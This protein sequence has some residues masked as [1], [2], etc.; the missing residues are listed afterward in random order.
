[1]IDNITQFLGIIIIQNKFISIDVW[2]FV[3]ILSG[4]L[5]MFILSGFT[6]GFKRFEWLFGLLVIWEIFE[7]ILYGLFKFEWISSEIFVNVVW[8]IITGMIGGGIVA[9]LLMLRGK[10]K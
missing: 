7:F 3:H 1:M 8:D 9:L 10:K 4:M 5:L 6:N 2:S